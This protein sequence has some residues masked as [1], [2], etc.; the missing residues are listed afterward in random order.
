MHWCLF[1]SACISLSTSHCSH[2]SPHTSPCGTTQSG[3]KNDITYTC[4]IVP[5][6]ILIKIYF[7]FSLKIKDSI[8][9]NV[10]ISGSTISPRMQ[11]IFSA[12]PPTAFTSSYSQFLLCS[13]DD[14]S[15]P[16]VVLAFPEVMFRH[17][18]I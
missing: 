8:F 3:F 18:N 5:I 10:L 15:G 2:F 17:D 1:Y 7:K 12:L 4:T 6:N 13:Q 11:V 14:S 16:K 9:W